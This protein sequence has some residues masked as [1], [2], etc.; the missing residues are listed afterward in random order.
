MNEPRVYSV[1]EREQ[2]GR[3]VRALNHVMVIYRE[4][5]RDLARR[6][7]VS[8]G[9][10]TKYLRGT[11]PPLNVCLEI[12]A[13]IAQ[14]LGV[15]IDALYHYYTAGEYVTSVDLETV[16]SWIRSDSGQEA[17]PVLMQSIQD[18]YQR[19]APAAQLPAIPEVKAL[20]PAPWLWPAEELEDAGLT[21]RLRERLTL[22]PERVEA[23]VRD[24]QFDDDLIEGFA[25][26]CNYDIEAVRESFETRK[27][28]A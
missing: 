20:G 16:A 5:Q 8:L 17:I 21:E 4:S 9:T 22:T 24:G 11:V 12:Q 28:I 2:I 7:D 14:A 10:V 3:F 1:A 13:R 19:W 23:L 25:C 6:L 18:A 26:A 27:P 15:T